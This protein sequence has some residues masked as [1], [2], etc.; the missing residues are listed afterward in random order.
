MKKNKSIKYKKQRGGVIIPGFDKMKVLPVPKVSSF[1]PGIINPITPVH[2]VND[3]TIDSSTNTYFLKKFLKNWIKTEWWLNV[4][5][6]IRYVGLFIMI[7]LP[8]LCILLAFESMIIAINFVI[9]FL[10]KKVIKKI[11]KIL[12][13]KVK[14]PK[15]IPHIWII[16]WKILKIT[17]GGGKN[18][19]KKRKKAIEKNQSEVDYDESKKKY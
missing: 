13:I 16:F 10:Y 7:S 11:S 12:P 15:P 3:N 5:S 18:K 14:R 8:T 9:L 17:F 2:K 6:V 1:V 4:V 19:S